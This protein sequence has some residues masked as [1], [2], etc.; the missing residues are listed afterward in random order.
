MPRVSQP[1]SEGGDSQRG[2]I[3]L[4]SLVQ[5]WTWLLWGGLGTG[6]VHVLVVWLGS[7]SLSG[8]VP[9]LVLG[10]GHLLLFECF[11]LIWSVLMLSFK[12]QS[13]PGA[14]GLLLPIT[15]DLALAPVLGT[16]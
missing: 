16:F 2:V 6:T 9:R 7:S 5:A 8:C 3:V 15:L 14:G 13:W 1:E 10:S 12:K 4:L 11:H